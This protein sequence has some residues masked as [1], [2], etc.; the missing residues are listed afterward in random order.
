MSLDM[1]TSHL[2]STRTIQHIAHLVE[3]LGGNI[4]VL[5]KEVGTERKD[6]ENMQAWIPYA[7]L[8]QLM[9]LAAK[10]CQ[11]PD[12]GLLLTDMQQPVNMGALGLLMRS[13]SSLGENL[14]YLTRFYHLQNQSVKILLQR[15]DPV[16][17][18][19]RE[20]LWLGKLPT[21]QHCTLT[22]AHALKAVQYFLGDHWR[23][24]FITFTYAPPSNRSHYEAYF[25]CPV[26]F[27]QPTNAFGISSKDLDRKL[28]GSSPQVKQHLQGLVSKLAKSTELTLVQ[29]VKHLTRHL[30]HG[31][32][33]TQEYVAHLLQLH[34]K[35]LQRSLRES[36]TS[37]REI[38]ADSRLA[39]AE[40]F[41][42]DSDI[43][44]TTVAEMLGFSELSAFSRAFKAKHSQSPKDWR[45]LQADKI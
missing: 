16:C 7:A 45:R 32:Q 40:H 34:P 25:K 33:C 4:D 38:R 9:E 6:I 37:F 26:E 22:F 19:I 18:L 21:F 8:V 23:P 36:G 2:V 28:S 24:A 14:S 29:N 27:E 3:Q 17:Q 30:L 31:D 12:F 1:P 13:G 39:L 42:K 11:R 20:D 41:L 44:L 5:C 43:P 10:Q 35:Q 15:G